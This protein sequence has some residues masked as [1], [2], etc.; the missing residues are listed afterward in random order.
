MGVERAT[1]IVRGVVRAQGP[2]ARATVPAIFVAPREGRR[3]L[4]KQE[5]NARP[6]GTQWQG[7][8]QARPLAKPVVTRLLRKGPKPHGRDRAAGSVYESP[9]GEA[10]ARL[11]HDTVWENTDA[12]I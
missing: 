5:K 2:Q 9:V 12:I 10:D 7:R 6:C 4:E 1:K 3:P 11:N 8:I